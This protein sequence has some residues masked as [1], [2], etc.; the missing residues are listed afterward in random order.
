MVIFADLKSR[1]DNRIK[2]E[3]FRLSP[4][5]YKTCIIRPNPQLSLIFVQKVRCTS[6]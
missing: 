6:C 4:E 5:I 3:I 1:T 2:S